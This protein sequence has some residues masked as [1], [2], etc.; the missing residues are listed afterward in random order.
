MRPKRWTFPAV[1]GLLFAAL[2]AVGCPRKT[3]TPAPKT[4]SSTETSARKAASAAAK[5]APKAAATAEVSGTVKLADGKPLPAGWVAFHGKEASQTVLAP[6]DNGKFV[7]RAV[8]VG[9]GIRV[10]I[11]VAAIEASAARLDVQLREAVVRA[12]L[13]K[14]GGKDDAVLS[15]RIDEM[16]D[17]RKKL[18]EMQGALRGV[19]VSAKYSQRETTPLS[20]K[21]AAGAQ[22]INIALAP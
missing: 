5:P 4:D 13:M 22:T 3:E 11:D 15:K 7:A 8:P 2:L 19:K 18:S 6:I 1:L 20:Y 14:A 16:K 21:V 10:T 9:D 17:R 12:G